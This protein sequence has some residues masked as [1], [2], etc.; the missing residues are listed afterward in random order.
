VSAR[1]NGNDGG[2]LA[3]PMGLLGILLFELYFLGLGVITAYALWK[4]WPG[5]ELR[6][7]VQLFG[8]TFTVRAG[9]SARL[10]MVAGLAGALGA[11]IHAA[12]SFSSYVGNRTLVRS[13]A[14]WY[15]LRPVIGM[16]LGIVVYFFLRAGLVN[17]S[18]AAPVNPYGVAAV[19]SLVGM[20]SKQ[21]ADKL[22]ETFDQ[23]FHTS[24]DEDRA[25][26]LS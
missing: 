3:R 17:T 22:R 19:A 4:L 16:A 6:R 12:T 23:W 1:K 26:K 10:L 5:E 11:F 20:F 8:D 15:A 21:A 9:A 18:D 24:A 2:F 14:G 13:W 25:D 7:P